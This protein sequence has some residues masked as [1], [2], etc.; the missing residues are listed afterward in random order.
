MW[1]VE[2]GALGIFV[3]KGSF[4]EAA[5]KRRERAVR[6]RLLVPTFLSLPRLSPSFRALCAPPPPRIL[7]LITLQFVRSGGTGF[8][9]WTIRADRFR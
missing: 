8:R 9:S 5:A 6:S 7:L 1:P 4:L 2:F 3:R